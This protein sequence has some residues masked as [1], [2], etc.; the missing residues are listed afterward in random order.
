MK[1][2]KKF[3][4]EMEEML[5]GVILEEIE[6][7]KNTPWYK[8]KKRDMIKNKIESARDLMIRYATKS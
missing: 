6:L 5:V 4:E 1:L 8:F 2:S 7:L 3:S